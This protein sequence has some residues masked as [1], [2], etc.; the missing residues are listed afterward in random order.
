M[1]DDDDDH[2]KKLF[3]DSGYAALIAPPKVEAVTGE[4]KVCSHCAENLRHLLKSGKYD[5]YCSECRSKFNKEYGTR[6]RERM[7]RFKDRAAPV[8]LGAVFPRKKY[9]RR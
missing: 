6:R 2:Y 4:A 9:T 8:T 7:N 5:A 1:K 3:E